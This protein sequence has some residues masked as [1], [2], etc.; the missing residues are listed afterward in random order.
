MRIAYLTQSYPPMISGAA[1]VVEK[2]AT[3][4][5]KRGHDVLVIAA[6]DQD[7]PYTV[8]CGRLTIVRLNSIYNPLRVNQ[9]FMLFPHV[10]IL[11]ALKKFQ[12]DIIH[13]HEPLQ[14]AWTG[15]LYAHRNYIP[16]TLTVHQ[17]PQFAA[18]YLP[19]LPYLRKAVESTLWSYARSLL[20][21]F[22]SI[23]APSKTISS[24]LTSITGIQTIAISNGIDVQA[25]HPLLPSDDGLATRTKLNLPSNIPIVLHVGRLD[26]DKLADRVVLAAA[27]AMQK[28]NAHLLI[29][30]D[31]CEKDRLL[32]LC[33]SLGIAE[34]VH[35][36]KVICDQKQLAEI[37]RMSDLFITA[38]EIETQGLVLLE[39]AASGLPI[40]AINS[41]CIPELVHHQVNGLLSNPNDV[42]SLADNLITLLNNPTR[43]RQMGAEG[44]QL[45]E[46]HNIQHTW[47]LH[48]TLYQGLIKQILTRHGLVHSL[49]G[50]GV[51][52]SKRSLQTSE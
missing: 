7:H 41:T 46:A 34:R 3:A 5:A 9:R 45:V 48:E 14:T 20:K 40:A 16:I 31:G 4:M 6:S 21:Q 19:N 42:T 10:A 50:W 44:R 23:I 37:Y 51:E 11:H 15:I 17:V 26:A 29:V 25:F 47:S 2:L 28:T 27:R 36:T 33:H 32:K 43:A 38:S 22:D 13:A 30:G 49:K 52:R 24:L 35:F 39:A 8:Q 1:L 12:P 18:N